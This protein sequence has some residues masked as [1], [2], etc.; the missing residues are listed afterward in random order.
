MARD[1]FR[2]LL[3]LIVLAAL[4][5]VT[6]FAADPDP[7]SDPPDLPPLATAGLPPWNGVEDPDLS[8][9]FAALIERSGAL[10]YY[11]DSDGA[12]VIVVPSSGSSTLKARAAEELGISFSV[13][14]R[15]IEL[16]DIDEITKLVAERGWRPKMP[17][18][19]E[20][21][22]LFHAE[23]GKVRIYSDAP[24]SEFQH[25]LDRFPGTIDY[26]GHPIVQ[27]R[28]KDFEP[29]WGGARIISPDDPGQVCT[30]GF[31]V[32][33]ANNKHRML[34]A[35]H[36]FTKGMR[37]KSPEGTTF[38]IVKDDSAYTEMDIDSE[39]VGESY[40][41]MEGRIY[42]G[43]IN[44]TASLPVKYGAFD[45]LYG[46]SYCLSGAITGESCGW[47]MPF[48]QF[49]NTFTRNSPAGCPGDSGGSFYH[50]Q[51]T[52]VSARG[53]MEGGGIRNGCETENDIAFIVVWSKI[54]NGY[55]GITIMTGN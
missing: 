50:R 15:D 1:A 3:A 13:E 22:V 41:S 24:V 32:R 55:P 52:Y 12:I 25:V 4:T 10:G 19:R 42:V 16:S 47:S 30:S 48:K 40:V 51:S 18:A 8:R 35:G 5:P 14:T 23:S 20:P 26:M 33:N 2:P 7:P 39:L 28:H 46:Y 34:T 53:T 6:S 29:H 27:F 17:G 43:G 9:A 37:V 36:C 21:F 11:L 45:P 38:G 54:V 44:S 31:S 49:P